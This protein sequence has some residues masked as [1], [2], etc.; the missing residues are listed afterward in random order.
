[1]DSAIN[2]QRQLVSIAPGDE[3]ESPL[4]SMLLRAGET[5]EA[6]EIYAKLIASEEDPV[7]QLRSL[8]SLLNTGNF[9]TAMRVM[10]P[11]LDKQRDDWELLYRYGVCWQGLKNDEEARTRFEQILALPLPHDTPGRAAAAKLKQAQ[12]K[13]R[14]DNLRGSIPSCQHA[15]RHCRCSP[16]LKWYERLLGG[17]RRL[18]QFVTDC[19]GLPSR[20]DWH[21]WRP[22]VGSCEWSK[23]N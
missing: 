21:A 4:A 17:Q 16:N 14:S 7:R 23:I 19:Y 15:K 12:E 6:R 13:A 9:D 8:D 2:Y 22:W 18:L 3:T 11:L 10:E 1:M 5:N 20:T